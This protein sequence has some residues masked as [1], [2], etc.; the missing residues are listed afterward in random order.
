MRFA[1]IDQQNKQFPV[2]RLFSVLGVLGVRQSGYFAWKERSLWQPA[3]DT[4]TA[5]TGTKIMVF[6]AEAI[7]VKFLSCL[8]RPAQCR[9]WRWTGL[10]LA[11]SG[12][13]PPSSPRPVKRTAT[14]V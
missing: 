2:Q 11:A 5:E 6:R 13:P 12:Y 10:A 14:Q 1:L 8:A 7:V 3:D 4:G 9:G